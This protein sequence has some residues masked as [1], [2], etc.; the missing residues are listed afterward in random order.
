M[1]VPVKQEAGTCPLWV[2]DPSQSFWAGE[3][4]DSNLCAYG[5][6]IRAASPPSLGEL[7][8]SVCCPLC[9]SG[10][11]LPLSF[12]PSPPANPRATLRAH[13]FDRRTEK[14]LGAPGGSSEP[15]S[16]QH[17]VVWLLGTSCCLMVL[18]EGVLAVSELQQAASPAHGPEFLAGAR[19]CW[20]ATLATSPG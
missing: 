12:P 3:L 2:F 10:H 1:P 11:L 4:Q 18:Q 19:H 8:S 6:R 17:R 5:S 16:L 20:A 13:I 15:F 9:F 14:G 7:K